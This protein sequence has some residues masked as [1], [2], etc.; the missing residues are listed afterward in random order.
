MIDRGL[1]RADLDLDLLLAE[2]LLEVGHARAGA[3][4]ER[5]PGGVALHDDAVDAEGGAE[6]AQPGGAEQALDFG[7][8]GP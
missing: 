6:Q 3:G 8:G 1:G 7:G 2:G 4:G 5:D